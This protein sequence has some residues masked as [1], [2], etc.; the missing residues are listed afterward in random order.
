MLAAADAMIAKAREAM[1][2]QQLH[3]VLNAVWAV[4]AEANRYFAGQA[5]WALAKSDPGRQGTV[6]FVTA[7]VLRQVAILTLPFMPASAP[8]L[9]DLLAVPAD[10]R[11]F[12]YLGGH[13]RIAADTQLPIP[14]PVFPRYVDSEASAQA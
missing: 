11:Q 14:N 1:R 8:R 2:T 6:L 9:L 10:E 12:Q 7:E 3:Q 5:P 4:V 13:H